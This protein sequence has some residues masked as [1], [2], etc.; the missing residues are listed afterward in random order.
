MS[1][2]TVAPAARKLAPP[3][4]SLL[5]VLERGALGMAL[6][7]LV[8]FFATNSTSGD[9][10]TSAANIRNI[11]GNQ[12]VTGLIALAMVIPLLCG[13][14]D[15]SV[16]AI[17]GLANVTSAALISTH[18]APVWVGILGGIAI[19]VAA[20]CVNG[21]LVAGLKLNGFIVTLGTYTLVGGLIQLYTKGQS[22]FSGIPASFREWGSQEWIGLPRPFILFM[23]VGLLVWYGLS[24]TP[25]GRQLES[26]GSSERAA[27]LVGIRVDRSVFLAFLASGAIAGVA[28]ALMTSRTGGADPT[29]GPGY[30]F[31]ALTAVFLGATTIRPGHYNV[32]G[33]VLG[34]FFAA[35]AISGLS[36]LGAD[37]WITPTFNG[38]ALVVAVAISTVAARRREV[39]AESALR[40]Q[41]SSR[42]EPDGGAAVA[43]PGA[44]SPV[45]RP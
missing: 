24:H 25:F 27:R 3:R 42:D 34:V 14:F 36:L 1:T 12:S 15:L 33:T 2:E 22:I 31:P 35:I 21:I 20:G 9:A 7:V 38:A 5:T 17:A 11:L 37:T 8:V 39:R 29:A 43:P 26:I 45:D 10:F 40:A 4:V 6:V 44:G 16:A 30:L 28:G 41:M 23:V 18:G 13:Y 32:W 19:A